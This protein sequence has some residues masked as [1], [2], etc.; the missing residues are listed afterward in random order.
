MINKKNVQ[1]GF[2]GLLVLLLTAVTAIPTAAAVPTPVQVDLIEGDPEGGTIN[3]QTN[4]SWV[5]YDAGTCIGKCR[6]NTHIPSNAAA[7]TGQVPYPVVSTIWAQV[8]GSGGYIVCFN[9]TSIRFAQVWQ[10]VNGQWVFLSAAVYN[11]MICVRGHGEGV[12]GLF[13]LQPPPSVNPPRIIE[14][15]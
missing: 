7:T 14:D 8:E 15:T 13:G 12:F 4:Q 10:F 2:L 9:V 3:T 1:K 5:S 11:N 6:F